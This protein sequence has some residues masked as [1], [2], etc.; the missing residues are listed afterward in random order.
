MVRFSHLARDF[1]I[2]ALLM[3]MTAIA[4]CHSDDATGSF[5]AA[6]QSDCL[7]NLALLDQNGQSINLGSLKGKYVLINFIYTGCSGTCPM[8]TAKM[9]QVEKKLAPE[10]AKKVRLVSI[11]LDP[12]HDNSAQLLKYANEHGANG[13]DWIFLTGTPA[14]IDDYLAIF[15]IKRTRETDGSIDHVT[16]SFLLGPDGRQIRQ[17]DGIAV[18]PSTMADDVDRALSNG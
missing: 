3:W 13:A 9:S 6:N 10:L 1:A 8:L 4:G 7:P 12:E 16:T 15:K 17:Y 14:Q 5:P 2:I 18:T 11:T